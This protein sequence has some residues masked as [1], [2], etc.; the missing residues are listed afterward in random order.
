MADFIKKIKCG[1]KTYN[2][3]GSGKE[4]YFSSSNRTGGSKLKGIKLYNNELRCTSDNKSPSD[5]VI[6]QKIKESTQSGCFISSA[7][8]LTLNK[9]DDCEEL[10]TLRAFRD[11]KLLKTPEGTNLVNE[12]YEI[13][14]K[15]AKN[16]ENSK[17]NVEI[18]RYL[19][20]EYIEPCLKLIS[21]EQPVEAIE[22]YAE[23]VEKCLEMFSD[24]AVPVMIGCISSDKI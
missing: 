5:V 23:M 1:D 6:C 21:K 19:F 17:R 16:I 11:Q 22:L 4:V 14:P 3:S 20:N 18:S 8:I 13:A 12:Y 7:V 2:I 10:E 24:D 15:I 9:R